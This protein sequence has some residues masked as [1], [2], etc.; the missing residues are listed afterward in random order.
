MLSMP[1]CFL[2]SI[3]QN[4]ER[5]SLAL[6]ERKKCKPKHFGS[7]K[8]KALKMKQYLIGQPSN[9]NMSIVSRV[10]LLNEEDIFIN[11]YVMPFHEDYS[12]SPP[13]SE[14]SMEDEDESSHLKIEKNLTKKRCLNTRLSSDSKDAFPCINYSRGENLQLKLPMKR[15]RAV[16]TEYNLRKYTN[17]YCIHKTKP[18]LHIKATANDEIRKNRSRGE[19]KL[20]HAKRPLIKRYFDGSSIQPVKAT[21]EALLREKNSQLPTPT[22]TTYSDINSCNSSS[23][24]AA[25]QF[26]GSCIEIKQLLLKDTKIQSITNKS[27][28]KISNSI[29]DKNGLTSKDY[30]NPIAHNQKSPSLGISQLATAPPTL[31]QISGSPHSCGQNSMTNAKTTSAPDSFLPTPPPL[32]RMYSSEKQEDEAMSQGTTWNGQQRQPQHCCP[33]CNKKFDRSWVLKGHLRMHTGERP[34]V[35]PVCKKTFADRSNL[36][37]HQRTRNHHTWEWNCSSCGKAFSQRK[38]MERHQIEACRKYCLQQHRNT[39]STKAI[40]SILHSKPANIKDD[41]INDH[42]LS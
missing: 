13:M 2:K 40:F 8:N 20:K 19:Q 15:G 11:N 39:I 36:R 5:K 17:P 4:I 9:N 25:T 26:Q 18:S 6:K 35:C 10:L 1:H 14:D 23:L 37:A 34:F 27:E 3:Y 12:T 28:T 7:E 32:T 22:T 21:S 30:M 38:Y 24:S 33:H 16:H 29:K 42:V 41:E 31:K